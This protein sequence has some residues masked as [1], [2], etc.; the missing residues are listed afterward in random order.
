MVC[1][2]KH[3]VGEATPWFVDSHAHRQWQTTA[4]A[5]SS[6]IGDFA[7]GGRGTQWLIAVCALG[8]KHFVGSH[9][10]TLE[11]NRFAIGL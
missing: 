1:H 2:K 6:P 7:H 11:F 4:V 9:V 3:Q 5:F 8:L 10:A